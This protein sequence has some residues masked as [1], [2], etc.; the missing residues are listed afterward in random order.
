M[1]LNNS[2]PLLL[3]LI[4]II[5][6]LGMGYAASAHGSP[7]PANGTGISLQGASAAPAAQPS[8]AGIAASDPAVQHASFGGVCGNGVGTSCIINSC[9]CPSSCQVVQ[10]KSCPQ[11]GAECVCPQTQP[12][13]ASCNNYC[14]SSGGGSGSCGGSK[15]ISSPSTCYLTET[16][17]TDFQT[18]GNS[19]VYQS[20]TTQTTNTPQVGGV[21]AYNTY[22]A[23]DFLLCPLDANAQG[24]RHPAN[25]AY[26]YTGA[27][28][29]VAGDACLNSQ[30]SLQTQILFPTSIS[31]SAGAWA[32]ASPGSLQVNQPGS[33]SI[34]LLTYSPMLEVNGQGVISNGYDSN[35]YIFQDVPSQAQKALWTWHAVFANMNGYVPDSYTVSAKPTIAIT[36][37]VSG[38]SATTSSITIPAGGGATTPPTT[39]SPKTKLAPGG[40]G[41]QTAPSPSARAGASGSQ[42]SFAGACAP[43]SCILNSCTCPSSCQVVQDKSCPQL[44]AYC[45]CPLQTSRSSTTTLK[46]SIS[47]TSQSTT[48]SASLSTSV[49]T[50]MTTY[51]STT[52]SLQGQQYYTCTYPYS[53]SETSSLSGISA[54]RIPY[55]ENT[56]NG[57]STFSADVVPYLT[58]DFNIGAQNL[59]MYQSYDIFGP[60]SYYSPANAIDLFPM[61]TPSQFYVNYNNELVSGGGS[62]MGQLGSFISQLVGQGSGGGQ[63]G[64]G[65][66]QQGSG[67]ASGPISVAAM[68]TDFVFVLNMSGGGTYYLNA[69]RLIPQGYYNMSSNQPSGV[70]QG[71]CSTQQ[72]WDSAWSQYWANTMA[73]QGSITYPVAAP[74]SFG[75]AGTVCSLFP[76]GSADYYNC[77]YFT[78]LNISADYYGDVF[79]TG[80]NTKSELNCYSHN[81]NSCTPSTTQS[82]A[83]LEIKG[84][85]GSSPQGIISVYGSNVPVL[86]EIAATQT[87]GNVYAANASSGYIYAFQG[88][89]L[90]QEGSPIS[91]A[92]SQQNPVTG[93][94][95]GTL[96]ISNYLYKGGL[97]GVAF[98]GSAGVQNVIATGTVGGSTPWQGPGTE[99]DRAANHHPLGIQDVNGY[100]YV[101]DDWSAGMDWY[102]CNL[103]GGGC[104]ETHLNALV[105]RVLN[106]S[107]SNV[108]VNPT[109]FNDVWQ[110]QACGL[111]PNSAELPKGCSTELLAQAS[112]GVYCTPGC[113]VNAISTCTTGSGTGAVIGGGSARAGYNYACVAPG[114][115]SST[116]YSLATGTYAS[117]QTYPPYG[118]ILSANVTFKDSGNSYGF[119]SSG[120]CYNNMNNIRSPYPAIGPGLQDAYSS[121]PGLGFSVNYNSTVDIV[122]PTATKCENGF[123]GYCW[124]AIGK[125]VSTPQYAELLSARMNVENYTKLFAGYP[126]YSCYSTDSA[127]GGACVQSPDAGKLAGPVYT[128]SNPFYYLENQG[129]LQQLS[130]AGG[131]YSS[132][133]A[134]P[135]GTYKS[136]GT[137][138]QLS[139]SQTDVGWGQSTIISATASDPKDLVNIFISGANNGAAVAQGTG[140]ASYIVCQ[141]APGIGSSSALN[142]PGC[143]A[144]GSYTVTATQVDSQGNVGNPEPSST[145]TVQD[146]PYISLGSIIENLAATGTPA[147]DNVIAIAPDGAQAT[148]ELVFPDGST[149]SGG[150]NS[151]YVTG[152]IC[153]GPGTWCPSGDS[154]TSS[155]ITAQ[156]QGN[157][158]VSSTATLYYIPAATTVPTAPTGQIPVM[159]ESAI[160]GYLV[161][162]YEYTYKVTQAYSVDP[163]TSS[164]A[165]Y[166]CPAQSHSAPPQTATV[167]T[168][169]LITGNSNTLPAVVEG[170]STYLQSLVTAGYY[171]PNVSDYGLIVPRNIQYYAQGNRLFGYAYVNVSAC[172]GSGTGIDCSQN[173]QAL[174]N[175]TRQMQYDINTY[176]QPNTGAGSYRSG[177]ETMGEVQVQPAS[178]GQGL[179]PG[180]APAIFTANTAALYLENAPSILTVQLFELYKQ[181]LYDS[182]LYLFAN[183]TQYLL[184]Q[185]TQG[186]HHAGC[187][188]TGTHSLLGYQRLIYVF[189]DRFGNSFF[190]PVDADVANP[191]TLSLNITPTVGSQNANSTTIAI[192]GIAGTY[193]D[194]GT[195][196]TPL[197]NGQVYLYYGRDINYASYNAVLDPSN[198]IDCAFS[199]KGTVPASS[200]ISSDPVSA[201]DYANSNVLT[202]APDYNSLGACSPPPNSLLAQS[203]FQCNVYGSQGLKAA[204]S[205]GAQGEQRFCEPIFSNGTGVCTPQLGLFGIVTPSSDGTFNA[206]ITACGYGQES[207]TAKYYGYPGPEPVPATQVVLPQSESYIGFQS[208][209]EYSLITANV[210]NYQY[211]P[212]ETVAGFQIGLPLLSYGDISAAAVIAGMAAVLLIL[213]A[214]HWRKTARAAKRKQ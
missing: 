106:V 194:Y 118:W 49:S 43:D 116:Y 145:L 212:N 60:L 70:C 152:T 35:T 150:P 176:A 196:F 209:A 57:P 39:I 58:Y 134:A 67:Y 81:L 3:L 201:A 117:N 158:G 129:A 137:L 22:N 195:V 185:A 167:Y 178:Y 96:N 45:A 199:V 189:E 75:I 56:P 51:E 72:Q 48:T 83:I 157:A 146:T 191:V 71:G 169:A 5:P 18:Q 50:S 61:N 136:S 207:I 2:I 177:Y 180:A 42:A 124:G 92:F 204:C 151:G 40:T 99:F 110:Q 74:L 19:S 214:M 200:C 123:F 9:T 80:Y 114:T 17:T 16:A 155:T 202:Y 33:L 184:K 87:G 140:A 64:S 128:M 12:S 89:N 112:S 10:D 21:V 154:A 36:Y 198:A 172:S 27:Y 37:S 93:Q 94:Q 148:M 205:N 159:L 32:T 6:L 210:L 138:P 115:K 82:A 31:W 135:A 88:N 55:T 69:L 24:N 95:F 183:G 62:A 66:G 193:S 170:G 143:L 113:A 78:P 98:D 107:G 53:Y 208:G 90:V 164:N 23:P 144:P 29:N 147:P 168:D 182:P 100:L 30:S 15:S 11:T 13:A 166:T 1:R 20:G 141:T 162:P 38:T 63:Q 179:V 122:A 14:G 120:N 142:P 127:T 163:G 153:N 171:V 197:S 47:S 101:L 44:G 132:F 175:A 52:T 130:A 8:G 77:E 174:L 211:A 65:K 165:A 173:Y 139:I 131:F 79:V 91:L 86:D 213:Y 125:E 206:V 111:E 192:N 126:Q 103:W 7:A 73:T 109:N 41:S 4:S 108:P 133:P 161:V 54:T 25:Q 190:A 102:S 203:N 105:L 46:T 59:L 187:T 149:V 160:N 26:F 186:C 68:P 28:T 34:Q 156:E 181:V 104:P 84:A 119:C 121:I 76:S 97:F 188:T 85:A